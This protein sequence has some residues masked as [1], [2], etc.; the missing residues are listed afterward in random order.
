M[1]TLSKIVI[2]GIAGTT[3]MTL[4]SYYRSNKEGQQYRE[5]VLLNKLINRS[6]ALP[7]KINDNHP[8]GWVTHYAIGVL[9]VAA[10]YLFWKKSLHYPTPVRTAIIGSVSGVVAVIAWKV[11]FITNPNPPANNRMGY[12][13]VLFVAHIVFSAFALAA[14]KASEDEKLKV[15]KSP[16]QLIG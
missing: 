10:Y 14:Y 13:R 1:K 3:F 5:P 16:N 11:M 12:Y 9:F 8:A 15:T 4:Y 7:N 2:A 6:H